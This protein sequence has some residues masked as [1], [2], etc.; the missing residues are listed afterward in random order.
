M[1][2]KQEALPAMVPS[3][4]PTIANFDAVAMKAPFYLRCGAV[5]FDY[6]LIIIWPVLGLLLGRS[7][8]IDGAKLLTGELN[9]I[10]WLIAILVGLSNNVLLPLVTGQS[11]GKMAAGL[12]I[13]ASDGGH[14]SFGSLVFRQ[15]L[16]YLMTFGS[17]GLGFLFSVFSS[18]GRALHDYLA[19]TQVVFGST[20]IRTR[21]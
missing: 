4:K 19:G 6:L 17:L 16:G 13:V 2:S 1:S 11:L 3:R 15:T 10:A 8:G 14:P 5:A 7:L 9:N 20:S 12:R 21:T 18:K